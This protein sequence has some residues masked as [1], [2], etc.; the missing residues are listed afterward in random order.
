MAFPPES[1]LKKI[2]EKLE[3]V[4]GSLHLNKNATPLERFRWKLCQEILGYKQDHGLKQRDLAELLEVDESVVSRIL[5]HRIDNVS[6]DKLIEYLQKLEP[7]IDLK[8]G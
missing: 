5:R 6:T 3:K 2:R 4:E 7:T 8:V 1:K